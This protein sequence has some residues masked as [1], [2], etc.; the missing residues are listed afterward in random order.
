ME[1]GH[2]EVLIGSAEIKIA[3]SYRKKIILNRVPVAPD[4]RANRLE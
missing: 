2:H 3:V 4:G 1:R